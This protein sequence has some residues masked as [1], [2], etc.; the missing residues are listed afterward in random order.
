MFRQS[1]AIV[2]VGL[3]MVCQTAYADTHST[4]VLDSFIKTLDG[5]NLSDEVQSKVEAVL[6]DNQKL[7]QHR[8]HRVVD[9][10]LPGVRPGD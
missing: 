3:A 2:I 10:N 9:R 5:R 8:D 6:A 4:T 7:V 1:F